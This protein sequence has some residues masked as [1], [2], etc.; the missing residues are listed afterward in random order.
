M[1]FGIVLTPRS[2][3]QWTRAVVDA[4][5]RGYATVLLPDTLYTP[6]PLPALAA[7]A[8]VTTQLRLRPNV[9][10]APLRTIGATVREVTALQLLSDGRFELGLGTGR[11]DARGEAERLGM[12]W[13]SASE[14]RQ[15][16]ID[17]ATAIRAQVDPA[18]PLVIA[19]NGPRMLATAAAHADRI[20]LA[21]APDATEDDLADMVAAIAEHT[22]RDVRCTLQLVG[23]GERLPHWLSARL[24]HTADK[25]R[26]AGAA[27]LLPSDPQAAVDI[28]E[29]RSARYGID[30]LIVPGEL[31]EAFAPIL[32]LALGRQ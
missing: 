31:A 7:A 22:D 6:S 24:G 29:S 15:H 10:A 21:A 19:A 28:L 3:A 23:V 5:Q 30:E 26:D 32:D 11:P 4:E 8:A 1:R 12:P 18:P 13:G 20:L 27:G 16:L 25:L 2:G 9:L 14:R 17:T